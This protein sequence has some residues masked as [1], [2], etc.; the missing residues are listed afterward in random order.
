MRNS[1][2]EGARWRTL[3]TGRVR[4]G[5]ETLSVAVSLWLGPEDAL[6]RV[7]RPQWFRRVRFNRCCVGATRC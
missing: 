7:G 3:P 1:A 5:C 4:L 6:L 2:L